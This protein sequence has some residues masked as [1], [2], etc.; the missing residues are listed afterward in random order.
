[1]S[2]DYV[3]VNVDAND[4]TPEFPL[5]T[6]GS[7]DGGKN[8]FEYVR[9]NDGDG[10]TAAVA[11]H[12]V[13]GLDSGYPDGEVTNDPNSATI[14]A[15][16]QDPRG[17]LQRVITNL[18]YGWAQCWGRNKQVII[19]DNAVTQGQR[20]MAHATTSGGVDTHA[21][22]AEADLGVALEADG[23]T[24]ATQLDIGQVRIT[25]RC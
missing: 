18:Y 14:T 10:N 2:A 9:F 3:N 13:V 12:L 23:D 24:I 21:G 22:G 15:I 6:L 11:G 25:I 20:L 16:T 4:A 19:T 1:M 5:G 17:F 7:N 8:V